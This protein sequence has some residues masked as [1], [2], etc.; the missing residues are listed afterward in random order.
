MDNSFD[1][2]NAEFAEHE[3]SSFKQTLFLVIAYILN[4][5]GL[6]ISIYSLLPSTNMYLSLLSLLLGLFAFQA[7][8]KAK[9]GGDWKLVFKIPGIIAGVVL[10]VSCFVLYVLPY[11]SK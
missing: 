9:Q 3:R 7:V 4:A 11:I 2:Y 6:A 1:K 8:S 10:A 5:I